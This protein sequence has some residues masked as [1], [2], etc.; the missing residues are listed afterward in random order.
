MRSELQQRVAQGTF[1]V[2]PGA[3]APSDP[4]EAHA[5]VESLVQVEQ[6]RAVK[7]YRN[8]HT[9]YFLP[10]QWW[11]VLEAVGGLVLLT[12]RLAQGFGA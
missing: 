5:Q 8:R 2:S 10:I 4:Q 7:G 11:G 6:E 1:Q 3:A 9:L 12:T